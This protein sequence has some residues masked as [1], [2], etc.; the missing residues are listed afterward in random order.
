MIDLTG[1]G[2]VDDGA[3]AEKEQGLEDRVVPDME[4]AAAQ[5]EDNPILPSQGTA[6]GDPIT[7]VQ[8]RR[9]RRRS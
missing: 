4:Q 2:G 6:P 3:G 1:V 8:T 9:V 5:A 7:S